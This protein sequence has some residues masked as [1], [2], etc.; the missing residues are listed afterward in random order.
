MKA[1]AAILVELEKPLVLEEIQ[2]PKL[3]FGQVLVL[4]ICSSICGSQLGEIDGVKGEDPYLPHLLGHEGSGNVLEI[5]TFTGLST[6]SISLALPDNGSLIALDKN[7]ATNKVAVN[8]FKKAN[9]QIKIKTIINPALDSI[10]QLK[11][12]NKIFDMVFIDAD[13]ENYK[14]YFTQSLDLIDKDGL[15]IID[16]VLW[17]GEVIDEKKHWHLQGNWAPV[18]EEKTYN[19]LEVIGE[20]PNDLNGLYLRNGMNPQ[21]G[22][23]DHWFFGNGMI[24]GINIKVKIQNRNGTISILFQC[25]DPDSPTGSGF[26]HW[27]VANIPADSNS[28]S[29]GGPIPEGALETR[30]DIGAP[31]WVGPCP[32]ADGLHRYVFT[33]SCLKV[34]SIPVDSNSSGAL[35]GFM[36]NMN[37]IAQVSLTGIVVR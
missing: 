21:S 33:L 22:Y 1:L 13:K 3:T 19:N 20:I 7:N 28:I 9:Q 8:F 29:E 15:I 35:V 2:I 6:L 27:I 11:K 25:I 4:V 23:S 10:N 24:H 26:W 34:D 32:P 30:T 5:G 37:A 31:G 16:N 36:T 18:K 12:N 17:H 14:N